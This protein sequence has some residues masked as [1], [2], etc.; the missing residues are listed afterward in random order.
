M[1]TTFEDG[2][3]RFIGLLGFFLG[4]YACLRLRTL[5][6]RLHEWERRNLGAEGGRS[7]A[8]PGAAVNPPKAA[9]R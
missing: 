9:G 2:I 6:R 5:D 3:F 1:G 8:E 4:T 7:P